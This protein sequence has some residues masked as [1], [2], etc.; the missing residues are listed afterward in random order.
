[1]RY[2]LA[3]VNMC[4]VT[5]KKIASYTKQCLASFF[6]NGAA[7]C[8]NVLVTKNTYSFFFSW[9]GTHCGRTVCSMY[10]QWF[11]D[12]HYAC[13]VSFHPALWRFFLLVINEALDVSNKCTCDSRAIVSDL[14]IFVW[15][16]LIIYCTVQRSTFS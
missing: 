8:N 7:T 6:D 15:S 4:E 13:G 1:M 11:A 14:I 3:I 12:V 5:N 9:K 16:L 10:N 2:P